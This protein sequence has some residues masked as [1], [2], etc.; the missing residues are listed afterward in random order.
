MPDEPSGVYYALREQD[1]ASLAGG[2][3][4]WGIPEKY[5]SRRSRL[6]FH[7]ALR[8]LASQ[9]TGSKKAYYKIARARPLKGTNIGDFRDPEDWEEVLAEAHGALEG[10]IDSRRL[11]RFLRDQYN[12]D[13]VIFP[14]F[15]MGVPTAPQ[16]VILRPGKF[17]ARLGALSKVLGGVGTVSTLSK[18]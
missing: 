11:A 4:E 6:E 9:V 16:L 18:D 17:K 13:A 2:P 10:H 15:N 12:F 8:N 7:R 1:L 5:G 3:A 14:D